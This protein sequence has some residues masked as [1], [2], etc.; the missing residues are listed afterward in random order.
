MLQLVRAKKKK[1][2]KNFRILGEGPSILELFLEQ[3]LINLS[4][5]L[6]SIPVGY[7]EIVTILKTDSVRN[8]YLKVN[9]KF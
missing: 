2:K 8:S 6:G 1:Q 4:V 9:T 7:N 3:Q 5:H